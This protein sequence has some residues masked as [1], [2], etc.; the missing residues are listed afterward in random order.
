MLPCLHT[1]Q[2]C[3]EGVEVGNQ[4]LATH[5]RVRMPPRRHASRGAGVVARDEA[6]YEAGDG[7]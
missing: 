3:L 1:L 4:F 7:I 5:P 6:D 2:E